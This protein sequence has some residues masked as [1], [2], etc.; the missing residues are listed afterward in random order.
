MMGFSKGDIMMLKGAKTRC[1]T[2][3]RK[4]TRGAFVHFSEPGRGET[5]NHSM[6]EVGEGVAEGPETSSSQQHK[7]AGV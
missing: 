1:G 4:I 2:T 6:F 3:D 7:M 5:P